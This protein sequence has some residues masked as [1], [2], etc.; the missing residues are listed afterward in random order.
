MNRR[1]ILLFCREEFSKTGIPLV[2]LA[3][4]GETASPPYLSLTELASYR[5][6]EIGMDPPQIEFMEALLSDLGMASSESRE[7]SLLMLRR[8]EAIEFGPIRCLPAH[9][10]MNLGEQLS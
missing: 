10:V 8:L 9:S 4:E 6:P 5:D 7:A 2:L 3:Y 1:L